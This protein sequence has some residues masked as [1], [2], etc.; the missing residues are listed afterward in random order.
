MNKQETVKQIKELIEEKKRLLEGD[1][2]DYTFE[3]D[4][5]VLKKALKIIEEKPKGV[6]VATTSSESYDWMAVG[7]T[8]D[9]AVNAIVKEWNKGANRAKMTREELEDYYCIWREFVKIG[10]C[11]WM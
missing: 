1:E 11:E 10:E 2:L 3:Y 6:W 4:I 8:E 9:E 5:E 7:Q